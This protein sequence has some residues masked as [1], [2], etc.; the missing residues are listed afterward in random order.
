MPTFKMDRPM[1]LLKSILL[2]GT[3]IAF[4]SCITENNNDSD[5][6]QSQV[7]LSSLVISSSSMVDKSISS[8]SD[9]TLVLSSSLSSSSDTTFVSSTSLSSSSF[10]SSS[11]DTTILYLNPL[12]NITL[13]ESD[14]LQTLIESCEESI[15]SQNLILNNPQISLQQSSSSSQCQYYDLESNAYEIISVGTYQAMDETLTLYM[16]SH[17]NATAYQKFDWIKTI[18]NQDY[19]IKGQLAKTNRKSTCTQQFSS[20]N[21]RECFILLRSNETTPIDCSEL[22]LTIDYAPS[23]TNCGLRLDINGQEE[24]FF[25][26]TPS[27]DTSL[28]SNSQL[29]FQP[30]S[31]P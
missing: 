6:G 5:Q 8:S 14:S 15:K 27:S 21:I 29:F 12:D 20:I 26:L 25:K 9:T 23:V 22:N 28:S 16:G 30:L 2:L 13:L 17:H 18:N 11:S 1:R 4:Q 10:T 3:S 24:S 31:N 7:A 19:L